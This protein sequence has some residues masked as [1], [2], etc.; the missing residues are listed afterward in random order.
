MFIVEEWSYECLNGF[1]S[2]IK[3]DFF[4]LVIMGL[5]QLFYWMLCYSWYIKGGFL[6]SFMLYGFF[7]W[8]VG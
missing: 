5:V 1:S 3:I 7:V 2:R 4:F 6:L 8:I